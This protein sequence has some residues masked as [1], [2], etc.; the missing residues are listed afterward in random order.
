MKN[1]T[2]SKLFMDVIVLLIIRH[3]LQTRSA[4]HYPHHS[5]VF[6]QMAPAGPPSLPPSSAT[7]PRGS[8]G[9]ILWALSEGGGGAVAV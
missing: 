4:L 1:I 3:H 2:G 9:H 8:P 7:L 5:W 6:K